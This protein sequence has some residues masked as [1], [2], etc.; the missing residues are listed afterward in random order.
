MILFWLERERE[1]AGEGER[2]EGRRKRES[3]RDRE[4]V[5][6]NGEESDGGETGERD[7]KRG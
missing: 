3:G 7:R 1:R 5:R 4:K 2:G 6:K